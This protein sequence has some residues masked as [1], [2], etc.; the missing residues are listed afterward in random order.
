MLILEN[1]RLIIFFKLADGVVS[2][3]SEKQTLTSTS[4]MEVE[5]VS[6]FEARSHG[7]WL[8]GFI[9]RLRI[10]DSIYRPLKL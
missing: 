2:W 6:C 4:T 8:K 9:F 7:V 3:R 10:V 5:F 1:Q